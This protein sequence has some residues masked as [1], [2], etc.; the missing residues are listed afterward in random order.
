MYPILFKIGPITVY[1][2]GFWIA[3]GLL[4]SFWV[5][6]RE[7]NRVGLDGKLVTDIAFWTIVFALV[8][9]KFGLILEEPDY[10]L[11]HPKDL[12]N[13]GGVF[14]AGLIGG[15]IFVFIY[16][17]KK[18]LPFWK[19]MDLYA[20]VIPLGHGFGRQGCFA[21]GCCYGRETGSPLGVVF[22]S[23]L[24]H[25][26]VGT[27]LG[28][29]I[30]PVQLYESF[31][32]FALFAFLYFFL[33]KRKKFDGQISA[34]YLIGYGL[35]RFHDEYYRGDPGRGW[36]IKGDSPWTSLST[37][38]FISLILIASGILIYVIRKKKHEQENRVAGGKRRKKA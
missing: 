20:L 22:H 34:A 29:K 12:I 38:Q 11:A 18:G 26:K 13:A 32:N 35:I 4:L 31:L 24:A 28:V 19:V 1:S 27:P 9:S 2:Y 14:Y 21:A 37:P 10:F 33:R 5:L 17:K 16:I 30:H 36:I 7:A 8:V 23:E 6:S 15:F 25:Q 3:V